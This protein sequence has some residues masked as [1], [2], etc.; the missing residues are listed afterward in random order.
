[1]RTRLLIS[2]TL[3]LVLAMG[4]TFINLKEVSGAS[5]QILTVTRVKSAPSGLSDAVWEKAKA[6]IIPFEGKEKFA[7][8]N[9]NVTTKAVYSGEDIYFLF[10]STHFLSIFAMPSQPRSINKV[11]T[12]VIAAIASITA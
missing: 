11:S 9:A 10:K 4:A 3:C 1:M 7:E 6:L 12:V 2:I 5:K 8:K